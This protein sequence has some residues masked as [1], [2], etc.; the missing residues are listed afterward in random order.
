MNHFLS[1]I[2][3]LFFIEQGVLAL[4]TTKRPHCLNFTTSGI[5]PGNHCVITNFFVTDTEQASNRKCIHCKIRSLNLS[6]P[7][8]CSQLFSCARFVFYSNNLFERFFDRYQLL[9][10]NR[11]RRPLNQTI[12][13]TLIVTLNDTHSSGQRFPNITPLISMHYPRLVITVKNNVPLDS[14]Q[15]LKDLRLLPSS[16][17]K[18]AKLNLVVCELNKTRIKYTIH[19]NSSNMAALVNGTCMPLRSEKEK[20]QIRLDMILFATETAKQPVDKIDPMTPIFL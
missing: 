16:T 9:I 1:L 12:E 20:V 13:P 10:R 4:S 3:F 17:M 6:I 19:A 15:T 2:S 18:I 8:N 11:I 5:E 14:S 7:K